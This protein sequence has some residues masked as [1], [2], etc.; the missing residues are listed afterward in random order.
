MSKKQNT[1]NKLKQKQKQKQTVIVKIDNSK[2]T[3][4]TNKPSQ[5]QPQQP[6]YNTPQVIYQPMPQYPQ[7]PQTPQNPQQQPQNIT[8]HPPNINVHPP[9]INNTQPNINVH[10]PNINVHPPNINVHPPTINNTQPNININPP[11]I[12][13]NITQPPQANDYNNLVNSFLKKN[14]E[15]KNNISEE[16]KNLN[17]AFKTGYTL[18][19]QPQTP[20]R[21]PNPNKIIILDN[22]EI[23]QT[24]IVSNNPMKAIKQLK[25]E[26]NQEVPVRQISISKSYNTN[27]EFKT[28]KLIPQKDDFETGKLSLEYKPNLTAFDENIASLRQTELNY[29]D[30]KKPDE[31][32]KSDSDIANENK[33]KVFN[34]EDIRTKEN[35]PFCGF[36]SDTKSNLIRH[37]KDVHTAKGTDIVKKDNN[38]NNVKF[39]GS[40]VYTRKSRNGETYDTFDNTVINQAVQNKQN[41]FESAGLRMTTAQKTEKAREAKANKQFVESIKK[42][43]TKIIDE[44]QNEI[45]QLMKQLDEDTKLVRKMTSK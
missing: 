20:Q 30:E 24:P 10:P 25:Q 17:S 32:K 37:I 34:G 31:N 12:T 9:T 8:I 1:K 11:N 13:T 42:G 23:T 27:S 36:Y 28:P 33:L 38:G 35:C 5:P 22:N 44:R 18:A 4:R 15:F 7:Y 43:D 14:E 3:I 6:R 45:D 26:P 40:D 41:L 21:I 29:L 19:Q 2:K 39:N 16:V